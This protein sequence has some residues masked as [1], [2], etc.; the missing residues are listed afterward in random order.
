MISTLLITVDND[1]ATA[2]YHGDAYD[3]L[4][5][6]ATAADMII[7]QYPKELQQKARIEFISMLNEAKVGKLYEDK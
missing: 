6:I 7:N 1:G 4:K 5:G 2:D 3:L